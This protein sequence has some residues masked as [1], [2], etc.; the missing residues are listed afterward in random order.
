MSKDMTAEKTKELW[1]EAQKRAR[2]NFSDAYGVDEWEELDKY[3]REDCVHA[4]YEKLIKEENEANHF[5]SDAEKMRD[6]KE[7]SKEEFLASYSYL[8]EAEYNNTAREMAVEIQNFYDEFTD[9]PDP[10]VVSQILT[11]MEQRGVPAVLASYAEDIADWQNSFKDELSRKEIEASNDVIRFLSVPTT[12]FTLYEDLTD[13]NDSMLFDSETVIAV[14]TTPEGKEMSLEVRGDVRVSPYDN[15]GNACNETYRNYSEMPQDLKDAIKGG[16]LDEIAYVGNN[17]YFEVFYDRADV[18]VDNCSTVDTENHSPAE[19]YSLMA[20]MINQIEGRDVVPPTLEVYSITA[21]NGQYLQE[22]NTLGAEETRSIF[23]DRTE[24]E[25]TL[26]M[27]NDTRE[28]CYVLLAETPAGLEYNNQT[29]PPA[30]Q[31][32]TLYCGKLEYEVTPEV[33]KVLEGAMYWSHCEKLDSA[34]LRIAE[35]PDSKYTPDEIAELRRSVEQA[36]FAVRDRM[37]EM[38]KLGVPNWVGNGALAFGKDNDLRV[39]YMSEFFEK[40]KYSKEGNEKI[41]AQREQARKK[42]GREHGDD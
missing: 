12:Q 5:L 18:F 25:N 37:N 32:Y 30:S 34:E 22:D 27:L 39:H 13:I 19:I 23:Y 42:S 4:E 7:L 17:N 38:E 33:Q 15:E 29:V 40:S 20:D 8:T 6:F 26:E 10:P 24:A 31:N 3:Q 16:K 28:E 41:M 9:E 2:E 35:K 21:E 14:V 1:E 11:E 36:Q